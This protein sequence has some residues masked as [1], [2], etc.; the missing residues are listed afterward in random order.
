MCGS[1]KW[2]R[3][4]HAGNIKTGKNSITYLMVVPTNLLIDLNAIKVTFFA[5]RRNFG[6]DLCENICRLNVINKPSPAPS[7]KTPKKVSSEKQLFQHHYQQMV[8]KVFFCSVSICQT[9]FLPFLSL[10]GTF[11]LHFIQECL[12][13]NPVI[14]H[15]QRHFFSFTYLH[16]KD[17]SLWIVYFHLA[18][19]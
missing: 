11:Y 17:S 6:C 10:L 18:L 7:P 15:S 12:L 3:T 14:E 5:Y 9:P 2:T 13:L 16:P 19:A 1:E 8:S 4:F